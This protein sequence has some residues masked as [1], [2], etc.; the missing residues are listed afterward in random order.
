MCGGVLLP[1]KGW[2]VLVLV[3]RAVDFGSRGRGASPGGGRGAF[4]GP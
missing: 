4:G 3:G 2:F 1:F